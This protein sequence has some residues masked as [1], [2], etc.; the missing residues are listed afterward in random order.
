MTALRGQLTGEILGHPCFRE[1]K[2]S[3]LDAW[4]ALQSQSRAGFEST[5][6]YSDSY[7][8]LP[9]LEAVTDPVAVRPDARLRQHAQRK[10]WRVI[11]D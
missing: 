10:C 4:L 8:D 1:H 6:F 7:N 3:H 9:L 2:L 11:D 5:S